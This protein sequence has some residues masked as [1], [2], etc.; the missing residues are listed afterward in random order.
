MPKR[1]AAATQ[2][3]VPALNGGRASRFGQCRVLFALASFSTPHS[4]SKRRQH[5]LRVLLW[6][7]GRPD[8][9]NLPVWPDQ[10]RHAMSPQVFA[11][12]ET[13]LAPYAVSLDDRLV[14]V[15]KQRER[16]L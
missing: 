1:C 12:H 7:H 9:S 14:L 5:F 2:R 15:R 4:A 8:L 6:L 3:D 16:Q 13:F 10:E 11:A